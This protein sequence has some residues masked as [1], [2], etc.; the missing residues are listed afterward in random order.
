MDALTDLNYLDVLATMW[1]NHTTTKPDDAPTVISTFA[2][3]GGSSL[4][5]SAAGFREVGAVEFDDHAATV[6]RQNFPGVP[7]H[8]Q[9]IATVSGSDFAIPRGELDVFDGSP[10]CQGFS[11]SGRRHL[12]DPRNQLFREYVRLASELSPKVLVMENVSGMLK[13]KMRA[14][15]K[16][17]LQELRS[18]GDGYIVDAKLVTATFLGVPQ[19]RQ[20]VIFIG[21]RKDLG[22]QPRYPTPIQNIRTVRDALENV[23]PGN[24]PPLSDKMNT[25]A[26]LMMPGDTG[27]HALGRAGKKKSYFDTNKLDWDRPSPTLCKYEQGTGGG[28]VLH[29]DKPERVTVSELKRLQSFPD[30]FDLTTP[31]DSDPMKSYL[32][33]KA[34][35]G[36]S[37]PPLMMWYIAD[38]IATMLKA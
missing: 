33:Q 19:R 2:G 22:L 20:R 27:S 32:N 21:V 34:R 16:E 37:V 11:T 30:E 17:V 5:Y 24:R 8:H 12:S 35:I 3:C 14:I 23:P 7:M 1:R 15:A 6:F 10:P 25:L 4:G 31:G 26:A 13:G 29:P 9:D 36:N 28:C 18:C 38:T